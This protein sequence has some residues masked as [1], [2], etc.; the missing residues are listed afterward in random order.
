MFVLDNNST[1]L[2]GT[3]GENASSAQPSQHTFVEQERM[4]ARWPSMFGTPFPNNDAAS[5]TPAGHHH[6]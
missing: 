2:A 5:T 3:N 4:E 1:G 6:V